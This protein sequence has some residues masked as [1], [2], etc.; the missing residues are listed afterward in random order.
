MI[1][2]T[3]VLE[4]PPLGEDSSV[5]Q[6]TVV[7]IAFSVGDWIQE[8]E[9]LLEVETDK[10]TIEI[11]A[12]CSGTLEAVLLKVGDAVHS[13]L[14]FARLLVAQN[15][16][17]FAGDLQSESAVA[18]SGVAPAAGSDKSQAGE[19]LKSASVEAARRVIDSHP[20]LSGESGSADII[21]PANPGARRLAREL[22]IDLSQVTGSGRRGCITKE[23]V[24]RYS[25]QRGQSLAKGVEVG[26][27]AGRPLPDFSAFGAVRRESLTHIGVATSDN[28]AHAWSRIPHAWL[29]QTMDI[30]ELEDW[31]QQHK[32]E[33]RDQGGALTITVI[34]AK[35]VAMALK[36]FPKINSS[37]DE[38]ANEIVYRQY[39]DI[40]IA[41]DTEQGLVVP[42]LRQVDR[43]GLVVLSRELKLLSEKA[44]AR[45]LSPGDLQGA[46]I[47][48]SNLGGMGF[49][50]I[51]P[52][53]NWP[54]AAIIGLGASA[55]E[56][57]FCGGECVPRR[58]LTVTLG[59]DHRIINGADGARFLVHLKNLFEDMRLMLL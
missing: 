54:Q 11:P 59:F 43:K 15:E 41:V 17:E 58:M 32:H 50:A 8:G 16:V 40:G 3:R 29:Q 37:Y 36:T 6:G 12:Q 27:Q 46:G 57:R 2:T 7:A 49:S 30:T 55:I 31:R 56:P 18:P 5:G 14:A 26:Q 35:A 39:T 52:I 24:K 21:I 51:F 23:D 4:M 38:Q 44:R 34:L 28:M 19:F 53:V 25:K 47:T 10:V 13:G 20:A 42:A 9:T 48:I 45:K 33:V 1:G 22:G